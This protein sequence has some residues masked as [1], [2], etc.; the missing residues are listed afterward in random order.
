MP[1]L[2]AEHR[3]IVVDLPG[4][5]RSDMLQGNWGIDDYASALSSLLDL[6]GIGRR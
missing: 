4:F 6:R 1:A 3:L 5:G 2:I